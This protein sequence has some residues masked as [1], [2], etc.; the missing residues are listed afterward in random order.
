MQDCAGK[1]DGVHSMH[2]IL[3]MGSGK[4]GQTFA[5]GLQAV[6]PDLAAHDLKQNTPQG[7]KAVDAMAVAPA[8]LGG[9]GQTRV[10]LCLVTTEQALVAAGAAAPR[11][12]VETIRFDGS[13]CAPGPQQQAASVIPAAEV[14]QAVTA[15]LQAS[16]PWIHY[17]E[18]GAYN[19]ERTRV[20]GARREAEMAAVAAN[21]HEL[22]LPDRMAQATVCLQAGPAPL[23]LDPGP[24]DLPARADRVLDTIR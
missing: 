4:A 6:T 15:S 3:F 8:P 9:P 21:L 10:V 22:G 19:L 11:P 12:A 20:H 14:E 2:G 13:C 16:D 17:G 18:R 24:D 23:L 7:R 5:R 1:K